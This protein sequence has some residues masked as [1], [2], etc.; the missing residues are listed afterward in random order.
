MSL[1]LLFVVEGLRDFVLQYK[2]Q[3]MAVKLLL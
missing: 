3:G 2:P 1:M